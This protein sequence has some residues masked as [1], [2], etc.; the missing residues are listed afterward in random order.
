VP[1]F[2]ACSDALRMNSSALPTA[3]TEVV[4]GFDTTAAPL[5]KV[6]QRFGVAEYA[7]TRPVRALGPLRMPH[8]IGNSPFNTSTPWYCGFR[9]LSSRRSDLGFQLGVLHARFVGRP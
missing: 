3:S 7:F 1:G 6:I 9:K 4:K 2:L 8:E 5:A